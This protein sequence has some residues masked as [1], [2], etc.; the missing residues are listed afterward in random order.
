[1]LEFGGGLH[2]NMIKKYNLNKTARISELTEGNASHV[3]SKQE[4]KKALLNAFGKIS[5]GKMP[6]DIINGMS[7]EMIGWKED[8]DYMFQVNAIPYAQRELK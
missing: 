2:N 1:V 5:K 4:L 7:G 8:K 3:K 6:Q